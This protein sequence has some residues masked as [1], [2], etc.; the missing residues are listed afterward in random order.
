MAK[1]WSKKCDVLVSVTIWFVFFVIMMLL[2]VGRGGKR[3]KEKEISGNAR[4]RKWKG[5]NVIV[6]INAKSSWTV[7]LI[8]CHQICS[9]GIAVL[10]TDMIGLFNPR[11][12]GLTF[13]GRIKGNICHDCCCCP[14]IQT[15]C[16]WNSLHAFFWLLHICV[17]TE[18]TGCLSCTLT[19]WT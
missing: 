11:M 1:V 10:T 18:I 9:G 12:A 5:R 8:A 4:K 17:H 16:C 3:W 7:W 6:V 15:V 13:P 19:V 14:Y 2:L